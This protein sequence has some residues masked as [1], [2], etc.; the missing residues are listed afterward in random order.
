MNCVVG[1]ESFEYA[2]NQILNAGENV[3]KFT[4]NQLLTA[5]VDVRQFCSE[6]MQEILPET[7]NDS[8]QETSVLEETGKDDISSCEVLKK[9]DDESHRDELAKS[10]SCDEISVS[11]LSAVG[12]EETLEQN[13][14]KA[15]LIP[16]DI[17]QEA[18]EQTDIGMKTSVCGVDQPAHDGENQS[19][20]RSTNSVSSELLY[21]SVKA[22]GGTAEPED[23]KVDSLTSHQFATVSAKSDEHNILKNEVPSSDIA[24]SEALNDSTGEFFAS[25]YFLL[26]LVCLGILLPAYSDISHFHLFSV[27][28]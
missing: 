23:A 6:V 20:L 7:W 9:D 14:M 11:G 3:I 19:D 28:H 24:L 15:T 13:R 22:V 16:S 18:S 26:S 27:P 10:N 12:N 4:E 5:G 21:S 1:Q 25:C 17:L 8:S 2:E